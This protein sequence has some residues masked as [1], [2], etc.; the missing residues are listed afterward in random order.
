MLKYIDNKR[1]PR[2]IANYIENMNAE[3]DF[4]FWIKF[5]KGNKE[6]FTRPKYTEVLFR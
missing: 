5:L 4:R 6:N 2:P 3:C 1:K